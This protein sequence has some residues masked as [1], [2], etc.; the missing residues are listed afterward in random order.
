[1]TTPPVPRPR[2]PVRR[3]GTPIPADATALVYRAWSSPGG[4]ALPVGSAL[5]IA[6][7]V[8]LAF[9]KAGTDE[10]VEALAALAFFVLVLGVPAA[11]LTARATVF[12]EEG[13]RQRLFGRELLAPWP[14][15]RS[16][17]FL[18]YNL[19]SRGIVL[20]FNVITVALVQESGIPLTVPQLSWCGFGQYR[21]EARG[22][23]ECDRIWAW[24]LERG[25]AQETGRYLELNPAWDMH[26][27]M[28]ESQEFHF[29]L[30]PEGGPVTEE[31]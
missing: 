21:L 18:R 23:A 16:D 15:A 5:L 14:K 29:R 2:R 3:A 13:I 7:L 4:L 28:R 25:Y 8:L 17:F 26:Q 30:R 31:C 24:A 9:V 1:M 12:T 19:G 20:P 10:H 22:V 6:L 27:M 11:L